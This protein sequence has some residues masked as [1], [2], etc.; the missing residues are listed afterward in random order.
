MVAAPAYSWTGLY[1]GGNAGGAWGNFDPSTVAVVNPAT[2]LTAPNAA[3]VTALGATQ[4]IKPSGFVGGLQAGYNWQ[5]ANFVY[6]LE[7]DIES[8]HLSGSS[9]SA[10]AFA[11]AIP[12]ALAAS[13]S[14]TWLATAR[15]RIGFAANNWLLYATGGAAF[16]DLKGSFS[17]ADAIPHT[18]AASFSNTKVGYTVGGGVEAGIWG[19]WTAKAEYLYVNFGSVSGSGNLSAPLS[20]Q[21]L[22][23]SI[24]LKAN[25]VRLGLNYRFN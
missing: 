1:V 2:G 22:L 4:S 7:A 21:V 13:A 23:H 16:S 24:D 20:G 15:G 6:G 5:T 14:T 8:F 17:Y 11:G 25:I 18:E 3:I 19:G 10:G 9:N 12:V